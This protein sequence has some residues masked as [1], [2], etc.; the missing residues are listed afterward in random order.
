MPPQ[1]ILPPPDLPLGLL[2]LQSLEIAVLLRP[3]PEVPA[4]GHEV[5][6][7]FVGR[8]A[9]DPGQEDGDD[10]VGELVRC[11]RAVG[12]GVGLQAV[13]FVEHGVVDGVADEVVYVLGGGGGGI[14]LGLVGEGA[15]PRETIVRLAD[16]GRVG[17]GFTEQVGGEAGGEVFEGAQFRPDV[18]AGGCCARG[19]GEL[20]S[21]VVED[22]GEDG[23]G[24]ACVLDGLAGKEEAVVVDGGG[25]EGAILRGGGSGR[26]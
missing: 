25:A 9:L 23:L 7:H 15:A 17:E 10:L 5:E 11:A 24:A 16:Q 13:K 4:H 22:D 6:S 26:A 20:G 12:D 19:M 8:V 14:A 2:A 3:D 18:D 1:G 21:V